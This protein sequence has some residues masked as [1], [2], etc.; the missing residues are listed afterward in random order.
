MDLC[1]TVS[2]ILYCIENGERLTEVYC[3]LESMGQPHVT[4]DLGWS[5]S[6]KKKSEWEGICGEAV[7]NYCKLHS[8]YFPSKVRSNVKVFI[9]QLMHNR[10]ALK[11]Y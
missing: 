9:Y 5:N 7:V 8:G 4:E 10:V 2:K 11:E 1:L 6:Y 3:T